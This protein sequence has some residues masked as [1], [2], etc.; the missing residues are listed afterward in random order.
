VLPSSTSLH[1][2]AKFVIDAVKLNIPAYPKLIKKP[3]DMA[4]MKKKLETGEY[5]NA[6]RFWDDFK[7]MIKNCFTF[8]PEGT[9]VNQAGIQLQKIFDD[10]WQHLPPLREVSDGDEE[11]N[12]EESEDDRAS[13][14]SD[15]PEHPG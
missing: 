3:M 7:L 2:P 10:K 6:D 1:H 14:L 13:K 5:P 11:D 4:T 12:E 9:P 8:N 15:F